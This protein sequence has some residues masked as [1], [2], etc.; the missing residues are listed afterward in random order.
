[1]LDNK[2]LITTH[3]HSL[4]LETMETKLETGIGKILDLEE[5]NYPMMPDYKN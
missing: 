3:L 2:Q 4:I 1:M 5:P